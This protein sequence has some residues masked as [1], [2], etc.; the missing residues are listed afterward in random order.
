MNRYKIYGSGKIKNQLDLPIGETIEN[1]VNR[2]VNN[3]EPIRDGAPLIYNERSAGISP[4]CD[5]RTDRFAVAVEAMTK[6]QRAKVAKRLNDTNDG[7][8]EKPATDDPIA[9]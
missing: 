6:V 2:I 4:D 3:N 7:V 9:S 8:V 1:K 5:I